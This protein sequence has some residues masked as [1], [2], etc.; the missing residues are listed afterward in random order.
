MSANNLYRIGGIAVFVGIILFLGYLISPVFLALGALSFAIFTYALYR[1]FKTDAPGLS[2]VGAVLG[3]GGAVLL[4]VL[5]LASGAQNNVL[6]NFAIWAALFTP[7]LFF[8]ILAYQHPGA[9]MPRILALIGILG[10][11]GGLLNLIL[12]LIGGG[13]WSNPNNPALAPL[14]MGT[15]YVGMLTTL[16]WLVWTGILLLRRRA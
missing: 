9:G 6:Q 10:G 5:I 16:V 12:T 13:D 15:Y 14:I 1:L 8:G 11:I 7:P 4:A 2:L 3:I